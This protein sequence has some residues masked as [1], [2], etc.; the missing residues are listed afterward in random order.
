KNWRFG[1][2]ALLRRGSQHSGRTC[3]GAGLIISRP[4]T[5][6]GSRPGEQVVAQRASRYAAHRCP[7]AK[8]GRMADDPTQPREAWTLPSW[9]WSRLPRAAGE[10]LDAK[11][12]ILAAFGLA[13]MHLGWAG[14]DR[15]FGIQEDVTPRVLSGLPPLPSADAASLG[16]AL[17]T[18]AARV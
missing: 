7:A 5:I 11:K 8:E 9:T 14:L 16:P 6:V 12:L 13:L 4:M 2:R 17:A 1:I 15:M 10:A 18:A 3:L